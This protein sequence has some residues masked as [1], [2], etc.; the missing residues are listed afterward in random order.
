VAG[1]LPFFHR[2]W[3]GG[4]KAADR[5]CLCPRTPRGSQGD[6]GQ[7]GVLGNV[8][9]GEEPLQWDMGRRQDIPLTGELR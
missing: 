9:P 2:A 7:G 3:G 4:P 6:T 1:D 5:G 8:F